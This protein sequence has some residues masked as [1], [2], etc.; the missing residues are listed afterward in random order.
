MTVDEA[1]E[2]FSDLEYLGYTSH[3]HKK[4][5]IEKFRLVFPLTE[6]VTPDDIR[7]RKDEILSWAESA[8]K[9]TL[10]IVGPLNIWS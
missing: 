1:K 10:S 7:N 4:D 5:G 8:D 2:H 3:N 6:P 9:S